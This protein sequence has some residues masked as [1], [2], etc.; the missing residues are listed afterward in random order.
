M[1][2]G[3]RAR[4]RRPRGRAE[5]EHEEHLRRRS[6]ARSSGPPRTSAGSSATPTSSTRRCS[7]GCTTILYEGKPVGTPD[8]GRVLARHLAAQRAASL[9]T[10]P[11]AFRA[12]KQ[13]GPERRAP[14]AATT[15]RRFRTLFLAGERCDPDTLHWARATARRPG[16][17]PLVADRDR[18]GHR[19]QLRRASSMLPVKPG[20]PTKAVPGLRRRDPRRRR[21]ASCPPGEIG[22]HRHQAARC[23]PAACRRSGTTTTGFERPTSTRYPGLLPDRRRRLHRRGRLPL[24]HEP[25]RRHHQRGRPPALHRRRWRRCWPRTPTS[26]SAP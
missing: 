13:R 23:R 21:A 1:P 18:L 11:T 3:R 8:A 6:R 15:S 20:S 26:P 19:R 2:E 7:H 12:I 16:D 14:Q 9:F 24:R 22:T 4:Q 10:A 5:V 17:R 25:H